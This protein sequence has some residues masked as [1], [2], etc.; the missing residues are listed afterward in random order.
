[1]AARQ[2]GVLEEEGV[3]TLEIIHLRSSGEPIEA[4]TDSIRESIRSEGRGSEGATLYRRHGL[5]TDVAIHIRGDRPSALAAH[6]TLALREYGLVEHSVWEEIV[7]V[8][9]AEDPHT[10]VDQVGEST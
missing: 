4:L 9:V 5:D 6:L 3:K 7:P 8:E 1:L 10:A 2:G